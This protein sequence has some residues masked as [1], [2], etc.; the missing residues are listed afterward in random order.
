M[1]CCAHLSGTEPSKFTVESEPS[2]KEQEHQCQVN[3]ICISYLKFYRR[4]TATA[5]TILQRC[6]SE[7]SSFRD[8]MG[9]KLCVFKL[10]LTSNPIL[11]FDFYKEANYT[12]M[13]LLH[14]SD[15]LA[16]TQM[17]EAALIA[18]N[19]NETGCR[20]QRYGGEGPPCPPNAVF[21]F[22]Y[23]VGARADQMKPIC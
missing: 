23:I 12:H 13:T 11:R 4:Q 7:V 16:V 6:L 10:G 19:L 8:R 22:V 17:L 15:Q 9:R 20:N 14:V 5:G 18:F 21:H 1:E 2:L 3:G